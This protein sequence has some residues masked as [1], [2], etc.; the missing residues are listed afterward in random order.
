MTVFVCIT[1]P[2]ANPQRH[3][4]FKKRVPTRQWVSALPGGREVGGE[5]R[6]LPGAV[7]VHDCG[8]DPESL[9]PLFSKPT[10]TWKTTALSNMERALTWELSGHRPPKSPAHLTFTQPVTSQPCCRLPAAW[11]STQGWCISTAHTL[12]PHQALLRP[13]PPCPGRGEVKMAV[14]TQT[15]IPG[16]GLRKGKRMWHFEAHHSHL[17][18]WSAGHLSSVTSNIRLNC[19]G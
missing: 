19:R 15:P 12:Q 5:R 1:S 8:A 13:A 11:A 6:S 18:C 9:R 16:L 14:T 2:Q 7:R 3:H 17:I 10:W 4:E